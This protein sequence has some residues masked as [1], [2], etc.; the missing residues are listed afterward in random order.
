MMTIVKTKTATTP[1]F[2]LLNI[3]VSMNADELRQL[4]R[5]C[6]ADD[7]GF[8]AVDRPE[9]DSDRE[10]IKLAFPRTRTL[11][12]FVSRMIPDNIRTPL[13][14]I[15]NVEFHNTGD[16]V[17]QI[18]RAILKRLADKGV[19]GVYPSMGFPM[20]MDR[21]PGKIWSVSH[22]LVAEA[23]GLGRMG[24]HRNIIHPQFG[25]FVL[26]GTIFIDAEVT[27]QSQPLD[28]NPCLECKLCVAACPVGAIGMDGYFDFGAC[29]NHNYKE[30]MGGFQNYVET[31]ADAKNG[32]ALRDEV[33]DAEH[34]SWWQSLSFGANYKA[35]YCLSV[36]PAGEDVIGPYLENKGAFTRTT[37]KPLTDKAENIYVVKNSDAEDHVTKR[38]P[39]KSVRHVANA[40]RPTSVEKFLRGLPLVF[41]RHQADGMDAVYHFRFSGAEVREATI[42]IRGKSIQ[43]EDGLV[44]KA[45]LTVSADART[46]IGFLRQEKNLVWALLTRKLRLKGD[47]RLLVKFGKCL[48]I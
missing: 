14:S 32:K 46:W 27:E 29:M 30:F 43:V 2:S 10:D 40:L 33:T 8:V 26:L 16:R 18:A 21:Y 31:V 20:E 45:D 34:G 48:P 17:E 15:A 42:T 36:C 3:P 7:A 19:R 6:G 13:R 11:I 38:F 37:L 25:N 22:K 47:P 44:G 23:A 35:A 28:Y 5:D 39:K 4:C 12:G 24:I 1:S 9:L 41:N